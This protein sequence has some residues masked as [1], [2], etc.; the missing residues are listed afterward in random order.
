MSKL[1]TASWV[2]RGPYEWGYCKRSYA[3]KAPRSHYDHVTKSLV[4]NM[5]HYCPWMFNVVG[6]ANYRYFILFLL[7]ICVACLYGIGI[8]LVPFLKLVVRKD[9]AFRLGSEARTAVSFTFVLALSIGIAVAVLFIWHVYLV[10]TAQTTIEFYGNYTLSV[11]AKARGRRFRNPYDRGGVL[12]WQ[13]VFGPG[14]PLLAILPSRRPPPA[15]PWPEPAKAY[16]QLEV[17]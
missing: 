13:L 8:T 6:F 12:N 5:D 17:V 2:D 7:W 3:P 16:S 11:R 14:H 10:M 1:S 15:A 9:R 4:L